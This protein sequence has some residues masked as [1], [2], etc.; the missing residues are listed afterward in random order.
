MSPISSRKS[1]PSS[2]ARNLP[3]RSAWAPVKA[4]RTWPKS[5]LSRRSAGMAVQLSGTNSLADRG[6]KSWIARATS[7]LPVP[8]SPVIS[9]VLRAGARDGSVCGQHDDRHVGVDCSQARQE[10]EPA[11][12]RHL[13]VGEHEI[14]LVCLQVLERALRAL[15]AVRFEAELLDQ[16]LH[17]AA[18]AL[19]VVDHQHSLHC[20]CSPA[21]GRSTRKTLP[22]PISLCTEIRP[23]CS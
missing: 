2:A 14:D 10:F 5:S 3:T 15:G 8:V 11:D 17:H 20:D 22:R 7:S 21:I 23:L 1:V 4:P 16:D 13:E 6:L 18:H 19:L 12:P 9:T